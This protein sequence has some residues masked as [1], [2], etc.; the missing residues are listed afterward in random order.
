MVASAITEEQRT[1]VLVGTSAKVPIVG[2]KN[3]DAGLSGYGD[4]DLLA[5]SCA[6]GEVSA[7]LMRS[8]RLEIGRS[9]RG[10]VCDHVPG[11]RSHILLSPP[12]RC[13][14]WQIDV[15][16]SPSKCGYPFLSFRAV[17]G[18]T[19]LHPSGLRILDPGAEAV[20]RV[21]FHGLSLR[22]RSAPEQMRPDPTIA[23]LAAALPIVM[24]AIA[25][26]SPPLAR[27]VLRRICRALISGSEVS[28]H[29]SVLAAAGFAA[30]TVRHPWFL[31]KR[32]LFRLRLRATEAPCAAALLAR[33]FRR[34]R[35]S[36]RP[37]V[38]DWAFA[39]MG[40]SDMRACPDQYD[41]WDRAR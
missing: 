11:L 17:E 33:D 26:F 6:R 16:I 36:L 28:W 30:A 29:D 25:R 7:E 15:Y 9:V 10:I 34:D 12:P 4:V 13:E 22:G 14:V 40:G 19:V 8:A 20:L 24:T 21:I 5:P 31:V 23:D 38:A 37:E 39:S 35:F 32:A 18:L 27:P 3:L 41:V 2:L 1:K